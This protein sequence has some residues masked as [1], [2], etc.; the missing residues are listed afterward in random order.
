MDMPDRSD[1][2]D[3]R[4][5]EEVWE[6]LPWYVNGTLAGVE[7]DAVARH[8]MRC[9]ICADEVVRCKSMSA[10][11][12]SAEDALPGP[13]PDNLARLMARIDRGGAA[14]SER[15]QIRCG[16]WLEK[17]R[18]AFQE[19]PSF[20]RWALGVQTAV[21]VVLAAAILFQ[22]SF[23]PF[24]RYRTLSDAG[25]GA[26]PARVYFQV[27]FADDIAE[28]EIRTLLGRVGATIVA[29]PS[30]MAVYTVAVPADNREAPARTQEVLAVLRAHPKVRLAE[31]E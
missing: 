11:I 17:I 15:R 9:Q 14:A 2:S 20:S 18:R 30:P 24:S 28:R 22:A 29:G 27:V 10:A 8:I 4:R 1:Q 21:V 12:R 7:H 5:H 31:A 13:A 6:I 26:G 23:A 3:A 25:S 19:T 16:L